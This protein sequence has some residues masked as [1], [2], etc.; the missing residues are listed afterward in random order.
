VKA[1]TSAVPLATTA[2]TAWR[3]GQ[4][5]RAAVDRCLLEQAATQRSR[6]DG[7]RVP[8]RDDRALAA[9][10][11]RGGPR[12]GRGSCCRPRSQGRS[13]V[14]AEAR[15][16]VVEMRAWASGAGDVS[17]GCRATWT[18]VAPDPP[19]P[20]G[21]RLV[22]DH[23]R[24]TGRP[25]RTRGLTPTPGARS[26][27]AGRRR[28][29]RGRAR[30]PSRA[31]PGCRA[32]RRRPA[33]PRARDP[34]SRR[35]SRAGGTTSRTISSRCGGTRW[36]RDRHRLAL[37][38]QAPWHRRE[39]RQVDPLENRDNRRQ[40]ELIHVPAGTDLLFAAARCRPRRPCP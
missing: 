3:D 23:Q 9:N 36:L 12:P 24:V 19:R 39:A 17:A 11:R 8:R 5:G 30:S 32:P 35:A 38:P 37:G 15:R 1:S 26:R 27:R 16:E 13:R 2:V 7:D 20:A 33:R 29:R 34:G 18:W 14:R 4:H 21:R 40:P 28:S 22:A 25:L 10:A 6:V 31:P